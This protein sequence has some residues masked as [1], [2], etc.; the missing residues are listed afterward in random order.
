MWKAGGLLWGEVACYEKPLYR[1]IPS[2]YYAPMQPHSGRGRKWR[3][4]IRKHRVTLLVAFA[5]LGTMVVVG[6]LTYM[7]TSMSCRPRF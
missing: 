2:P 7:L 3:R 6:F 1:S 5:A 4:F